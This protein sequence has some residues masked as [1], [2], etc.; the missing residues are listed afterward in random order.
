MTQDYPD[1]TRLFHLVGTSITIP[2]NITASDV[3]LPVSIEAV[4]AELDVFIVGQFLTLSMRITSCA[5]TLNVNIAAA[6]VTV[7]I[8]F[9]DQSV[10]VWDAT[11]WFSHQG[12]AK[13]WQNYD[14]V[15]GSYDDTIAL[16]TVPDGKVLYVYEVTI[17]WQ[18]SGRGIAL[19][20]PGAIYFAGG[21]VGDHGTLHEL[22]SP[23]LALEAGKTL[24]IYL[25]NDSSDTAYY[26]YV[27]RGGEATA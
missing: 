25:R 9:T 24:Y 11:G 8:K 20:S 3:T 17:G 13:F 18:K 23:P 26:F 12:L 10:A 5:V 7:N 14:D 15:I 16:Y 27:I 21:F 22:L 2:I 4:T 1:W 19:Y 6:A